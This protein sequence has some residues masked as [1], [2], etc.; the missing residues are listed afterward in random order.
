LKKIKLFRFPTEKPHVH[1]TEVGRKIGDHTPVKLYT[2]THREENLK[3]GE[4]TRTQGRRVKTQTGG[5]EKPR[6]RFEWRQTI[7]PKNKHKKKLMGNNES[8][9]QKART[10][11][12]LLGK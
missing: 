4:P 8:M 5:G 11:G 12:V 7:Q 9:W 1:K 2:P 3:R 6:S 10:E